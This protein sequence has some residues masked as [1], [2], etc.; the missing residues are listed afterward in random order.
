[1]SNNNNKIARLIIEKS[2]NAR[3]IRKNIMNLKNFRQLS[4]LLEPTDQ[5]I[6]VYKRYN[7]I[8]LYFWRTDN[9]LKTHQHGMMTSTNR[10]VICSF[11]KNSD[12]CLARTRRIDT[13]S[14]ISATVPKKKSSSRSPVV[15]D[16]NTRR[17]SILI[18]QSFLRLE[19]K[20]KRQRTRVP[21]LQPSQRGMVERI[22]QPLI[23]Q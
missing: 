1:M 16:K 6:P 22:R 15:R 18:H 19:F 13:K 5:P 4:S 17:P 3:T 2:I 14:W 21:S 12:L 10:G 8:S 20:K 9:K 7:R 11:L 23:S